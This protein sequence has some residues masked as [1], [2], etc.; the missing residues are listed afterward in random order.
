MC[1]YP[2]NPSQLYNRNFPFEI[3]KLPN[4]KNKNLIFYNPPPSKILKE[5]DYE[6]KSIIDPCLLGGGNKVCISF[7][8]QIRY[9]APFHAAVDHPLQTRS[10]QLHSMQQ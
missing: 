6:H 4:I 10:I 3:N 1:M 8:S 7:R 5:R 2:F 9:P